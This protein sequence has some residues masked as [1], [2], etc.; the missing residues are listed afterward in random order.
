MVNNFF[1]QVS[2]CR[3]VVFASRTT[4]PHTGSLVYSG[5]RERGIIII[6]DGLAGFLK[7]KFITISRLGRH[8][9]GIPTISIPISKDS[10]YTAIPGVPTMYMYH[11]SQRLEFRLYTITI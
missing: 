4:A 9:Y 8:V 1:D 7:K 6:V 3:V 2:E 10:L 11:N 5:A